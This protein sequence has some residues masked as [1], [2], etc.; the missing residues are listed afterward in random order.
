V[1]FFWNVSGA[2][3]HNGVNQTED[4]L[5]VSWCL[6]K[7]A[8]HPDLSADLRSAFKNVGLTH[9]C[10]G[11]M[12]HPLVAA[13]Y[14]LQRAQGRGLVDGRV[15]PAKGAKYAHHHAK[16]I[17]LIFELNGFLRVMHPDQYPRLDL[18]SDF[19]WKLKE[20]AKAPFIV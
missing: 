7:A 18:M 11:R 4:V 8:Q 20:F 14:T 19:P 17:Y 3:G 15:S 1:V 16:H 9:V 2:V 6:Y 13:I 10:N 12:D 5:F